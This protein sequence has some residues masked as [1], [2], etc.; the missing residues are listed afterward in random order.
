[1]SVYAGLRGSSAQGPLARVR[2]QKPTAVPAAPSP[3]PPGIATR[4]GR[5]RALR[6]FGGDAIEPSPPKAE[7]ADETVFIQD[8]AIMKC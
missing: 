6:G 4:E 7:A 8:V 5:N 1:M 3:L 2:K